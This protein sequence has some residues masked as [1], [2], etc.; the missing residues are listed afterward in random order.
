M[1]SNLMLLQ[2]KRF[3]KIIVQLAMSQ[4]TSWSQVPKRVT[5]KNGREGFQKGVRHSFLQ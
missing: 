2:A 5:R 4:Q 3:T 1:Q